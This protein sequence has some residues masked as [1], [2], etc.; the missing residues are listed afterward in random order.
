MTKRLRMLA[1]GVVI[2]ALMLGFS[3]VFSAHEAQAESPPNPPARFAGTVLVDGKQPTAGTRIEAKVGN[4]TCGVSTTFA[5]GGNMNYALDVPALDPGAAPN[6][7]TGDAVVSFWI[8]DKQAKETGSW[9][10]YQLNLLNLSYT[11]PVVAPKPP[12]TGSGIESDGGSSLWLL[13]VLGAGLLVLGTGS[14]TVA[15]RGR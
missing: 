11:T 12:V 6:C 15:R 5:Q 2:G 7:G 9:K 14:A 1:G 10:N 4:S 13:V 8:G 3:G